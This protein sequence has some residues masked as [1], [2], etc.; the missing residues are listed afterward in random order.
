MVATDDEMGAAVVGANEPVPHGLARPAHAHR[1]IEQRHG[2]GRGWVLIEHRL[3]ATH[4]GEVIYVSRF[5]HADHWVNEQI[6]LG[7]FR[8]TKGQLL[9]G[10]V[11]RVAG[12]KGHHAAP[13][14]FAK[15]GAQLVGRVAPAAKVVMDRRLTAINGKYKD[16]VVVDGRVGPKT[17]KAIK[18][19]EADRLRAYRVLKFAEIVCK[20]PSQEKFWFGWFRRA[21]HV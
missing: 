14:H 21:L 17:I 16:A 11:E 10:A 1:Q 18:K 8:G 5:G 7:L 12:L 13:T 9:M 6:G 3:I 2:R 15:I 20:D 4:A 19:L